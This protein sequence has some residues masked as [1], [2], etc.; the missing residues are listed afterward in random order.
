MR[1]ELANGDGPRLVVV[2][3]G[4]ELRDRVVER[5]LSFIH[6][7]LDGDADDRLGHRP[8]AVDRV[9]RHFILLVAV[10]QPE[11]A[12]QDG[13]AVLDDQH[14]A[15]DDRVGLDEPVDHVDEGV[16]VLLSQT[17]T[18]RPGGR[19]RVGGGGG[20]EGRKGEKGKNCESG[21]HG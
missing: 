11:P 20:G 8:D 14:L 13:A 2:E 10:L 18:L 7:H 15:A 9:D 4:N 5:Q 17:D 19:E 12:A 21:P 3:R 16:E 6:E 1:Q